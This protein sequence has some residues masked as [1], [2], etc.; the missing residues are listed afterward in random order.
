MTS[1]C[2]YLFTNPCTVCVIYKKYDHL[3]KCVYVC[4]QTFYTHTSKLTKW[5]WGAKKNFLCFALINV[6]KS[7]CINKTFV[8]FGLLL[9]ICETF[10]TVLFIILSEERNS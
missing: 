10:Q 4:L 1:H 8:T 2:L 5:T 3:F 6:F 7:T 9:V